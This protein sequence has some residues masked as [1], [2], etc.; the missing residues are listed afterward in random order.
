M[1]ISERSEES[2][3]GSEPLGSTEM[4][5]V[6]ESEVVEDE[7]VPVVRVRRRKRTRSEKGIEVSSNVRVDGNRI[8]LKECQRLRESLRGKN[9]GVQRQRSC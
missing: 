4:P 2:K 9:E 8:L 1:K 5:D 7:D 6:V 3:G